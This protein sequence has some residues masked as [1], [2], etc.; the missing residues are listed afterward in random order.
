MSKSTRCRLLESATSICTDVVHL[1]DDYVGPQ[2]PLAVT[3][4][5]APPDQP[6]VHP[7]RLEGPVMRIFGLGLRSRSD[8]VVTD[9]IAFKLPEA[10]SQ[11]IDLVEKKLLHSPFVV[12]RQ[13]NFTSFY[14]FFPKKATSRWIVT[15]AQELDLSFVEDSGVYSLVTPFDVRD[16]RY[17]PNLVSVNRYVEVDDATIM[18]GLC[19]DVA[20]G[21]LSFK[22]HP[23]MGGSFIGTYH[24][25]QLDDQKLHLIHRDT[26]AGPSVWWFHAP[27]PSVD[28]SDGHTVSSWWLLSGD[29]PGQFGCNLKLLLPSGVVLWETQ[30]GHKDAQDIRDPFFT[31]CPRTN[32]VRCV[33]SEKRAWHRGECN[34]ANNFGFCNRLWT[35]P[36]VHHITYTE[37]DQGTKE[38]LAVLISHDI[39]HTKPWDPSVYCFCITPD[40]HI[41]VPLYNCAT[42]SSNIAV[43]TK[44]CLTTS[45]SPL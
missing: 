8:W 27:G 4:I 6:S 24:V 42:T 25:Y 37:E 3:F 22:T 9:E 17:E 18:W 16:P 30:L 23:P 41:R 40:Q 31:P 11:R 21:I 14:A 26:K 10:L 7:H 33:S 2:I 1:V 28:A 36:R 45:S 29:L 13:T 15:A 35:R 19:V 43:T 20:C 12:V 44:S 5:C 34:G 38:E 32:V 39:T